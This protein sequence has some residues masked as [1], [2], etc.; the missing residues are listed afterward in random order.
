MSYCDLNVRKEHHFLN[1]IFSKE[2]MKLS[3]SICNLESYYK[4]FELFLYVCGNLCL[5]Y[6][7]NYLVNMLRDKKILDFLNNSNGDG[8]E[9]LFKQISDVNVEGVNLVETI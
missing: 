5:N 7:K 4:E 1:D 2:E 6:T 3:R 9:D 8:F